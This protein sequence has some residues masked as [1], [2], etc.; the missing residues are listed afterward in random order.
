[1]MEMLKKTDANSGMVIPTTK[2][3]IFQKSGLFRAFRKKM[4]WCLEYLWHLS[5][6]LRIWRSNA[7]LFEGKELNSGELL[8]VFYFGNGENC[9]FVLKKIFSE[10]RI[11]EI[12]KGVLSFNAKKWMQKYSCVADML[13][14][15]VELLYSKILA[16]DNFLQIPQWIR[17]VYSIPDTWEGVLASF[18]KNTRKTDLR[19]VRKYNF[20]YKISTSDKDFKEFYHKMHVPYLQKRFDDL[21]IIEPEWK[22]L[23]QCRKGQLMQIIRE[24][25]VVAAVLLHM[26]D[27]RLAYVWVGV[28]EH[29]KGDMFN[30]AFSA[31]YYFTI[32]YGYLNGCREID[33]L[34]TRP[35]LNDGLFRYKR[36]W[37]THVLDSPIP[38]G[39]ILIKP[40]RLRCGLA[41]FFASY[42]FLA[43]DGKKLSGNILFDSGKLRRDDLSELIENYY[44]SG[45]KCLNIFCLNGFEEDASQTA[46]EHG[47]LLQL[48][49]LNSLEKSQDVFCNG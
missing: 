35:I 46:R 5:G 12:A 2:P 28:P 6:S 15:D 16:R 22:F 44:T 24:D 27:S 32:L 43:R 48:H 23:R 33:F 38:R 40:L 18:R 21:V 10:Y 25:E 47:G 19:K 34:G 37:G 30:G 45:I 39:D 3:H 4:G 29:I 7:I 14:A 36:K 49:D 31:M 41:H 13:F 20:S 17:Q 11:V 1:M 26:A 8:R 42:Y 9:E